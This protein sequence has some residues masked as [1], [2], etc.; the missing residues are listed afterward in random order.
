MIIATDPETRHFLLTRPGGCYTM[1]FQFH[2]RALNRQPTKPE[3]H[4]QCLEG[5]LSYLE[6]SHEVCTRDKLISMPY[7]LGHFQ[8]L[9]CVEII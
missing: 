6:M 3:Q 1:D 4:E 7:P 5:K 9:C 8:P 2:L